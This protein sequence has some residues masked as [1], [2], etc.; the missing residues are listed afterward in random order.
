MY[1]AGVCALLERF[2]CRKQ[3]QIQLYFTVYGNETLADYL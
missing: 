2:N 1:N 3:V